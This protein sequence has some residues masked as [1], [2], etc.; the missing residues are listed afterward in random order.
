MSLKKEQVKELS[1]L[2]TDEDIFIVFIKLVEFLQSEINEFIGS[3]KNEIV[4]DFMNSSFVKHDYSE[5]SN[6]NKEEIS[7]LTYYHLKQYFLKK[8]DRT[9]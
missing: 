4:K 9:T 5:I 6:D 3:N 7:K 8:L 1:E 2:L